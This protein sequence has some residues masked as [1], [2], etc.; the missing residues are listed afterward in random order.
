MAWIYW[1]PSIKAFTIPW[2]NHDVVWYGILFALGIFFSYFV[3]AHLIFKFFLRTLKGE[4]NLKAKAFACVDKLCLYLVSCMVLFSRLFHLLF[5]EK[6]DYIAADPLVIFK[7][8]EGGLSSHGGVIGLFVGMVLFLIRESRT[9]PVFSFVTLIDLIIVPGMLTGAFIR[10][11]NFIN[12]EILGTPTTHFFGVI[13]GSSSFAQHGIALHPVVLYE[14]LI[15]FV[16]CLFFSIKFSKWIYFRG[17]IAGWMFLTVFT[18][19][20]VLEFFKQSQSYYIESAHL[21]NMGQMLTLPLIVLG[22][23]LTY[24]SFKPSSALFMRDVREKEGA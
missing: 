5:Y 4:E 2:I 7:V 11:G 15:Y 8:W 20:F 22:F 12:Q 6:M 23:Y 17:R 18:A 24:Q 9:Y 13:F 19:R 10:V 21:L 16:A 1:N 14:A 3:L